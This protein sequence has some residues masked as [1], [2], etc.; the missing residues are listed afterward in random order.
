MNTG[1]HHDALLRR[2]GRTLDQQAGLTPAERARLGRA[3]REALQRP[4]RRLPLALPELP[5]GR[6][7][8]AASLVLTVALGLALTPFP[9]GP[10]PLPAALAEPQDWDWL[11]AAE[12]DPFWVEDLD[13]PAF[14]VWAAESQP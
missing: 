9:R 7:A 12:E 2:I 10:Q 14:L 1:E 13:D 5:V 3:R 6:L 8:L 4:V 11:M